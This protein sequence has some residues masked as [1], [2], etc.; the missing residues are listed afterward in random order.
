[1]ARRTDT[2]DKFKN[3]DKVRKVG[4]RLWSD[5]Y[6]FKRDIEYINENFFELFYILKLTDNI[7]LIIDTLNNGLRNLCSVFIDKTIRDIEAGKIAKNKFVSSKMKT[8]LEIT[9]YLKAECKKRGLKT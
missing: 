2:E 3:E 9:R 4:G 1:M 8:N 7:D 5:Y 6:S